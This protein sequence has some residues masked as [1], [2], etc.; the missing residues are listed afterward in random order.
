[1]KCQNFLC[2]KEAEAG[3]KYCSKAHAPFSHLEGGHNIDSMKM[4]KSSSMGPGDRSQIVSSE[5]K[6]SAPISKLNMRPMQ[7]LESILENND[8]NGPAKTMNEKKNDNEKD[9]HRSPI[10]S[11]E[12]LI[13][14]GWKEPEQI[15]S[16]PEKSIETGMPTIHP[17]SLGAPLLSSNA[18]KLISLNLI[19]DAV[20]RLH[21][22]LQNLTPSAKEKGQD[23]SL[24]ECRKLNQE[25]QAI[26]QTAC[27]TAVSMA[28]LIQLK[29]NG[30][31]LLRELSRSN[32]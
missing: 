17:E 11:N 15:E 24:T 27:L 31:K 26:A 20:G 25:D 12:K 8:V 22:Q 2:V 28:K 14:L 29:L 21:S 13:K 23:I 9:M 7:N 19:D 30:L 18:E 16:I 4:G 6:S 32:D 10:L 1:M 3:Q 5:K